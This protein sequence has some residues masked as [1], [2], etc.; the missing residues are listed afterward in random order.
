MLQIQ[1]FR[2]RVTPPIQPSMFSREFVPQLVLVE[3]ITRRPTAQLRSGSS[4]HIGNTVQLDP[5]GL[6][7]ALGR[8]TRSTLA[9]LDERTGNFIEAEF[10]SAPYTHVFCDTAIELVGIAQKP[11]LARTTLGIARKLQKILNLTADPVLNASFDIEPISDPNDF[12]KQIREA[13][14]VRRFAI[15][16]AL[17]N[18][19]DVN[20]D[21]HQPMERLLRDA[22]GRRGKTSLVG[23]EL[24]PDVLEELARSA[25]STGNDAEARLIRTAQ[26]KPERRKMRGDLVTESIDGNLTTDNE[27][28]VVLERLRKLYSRIRG[29]LIKGSK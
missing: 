14:A 9:Q 19:F 3:A 11:D 2:I 29:N 25:A 28:R 24:N 27:R 13:Y 22:T 16:F 8:I 17:P 23:E 15:T 10:P 7:F 21:F 1:L 18:P 5:F 4:W 6:Y 26:A 12:I 20:R